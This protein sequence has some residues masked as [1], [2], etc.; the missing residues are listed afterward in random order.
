[1]VPKSLSSTIKGKPKGNLMNNPIRCLLLLSLLLLSGCFNDSSSVKSE[2]NSTT[3]VQ[4]DRE[5]FVFDQAVESVDLLAH[6]KIGELHEIVDDHGVAAPIFQVEILDVLKGESVEGTITVF[7]EKEC[8]FALF[9][10]GEEWVL[11]LNKMEGDI[12]AD[13]GIEGSKDGVFQIDDSVIEGLR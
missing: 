4:F 9:E 8:G 11:F 1:M 10:E 12:E 13:Y 5:S 3:C 2:L 7:Q 6:V